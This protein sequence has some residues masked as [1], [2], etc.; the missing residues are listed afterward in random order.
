[1][2]RACPRYQKGYAAAISSYVS[3]CLL[4]NKEPWPVSTTILEEWAVTRIYGTTLS[5]QGQIKSDTVLS[6]LSALKS[7]HIDM[8]LSLKNF[9]DTRM[10]LIIKSGRRLFP[11]KKWNRLPI[12]NIIFEK[13]TEDKPLSVTD[14][15]VNTAFKVAWAGL[16]RMEEFTYKAAEAKK[17]TFAE[18]GLTR[19]DI[20]FAEGDQYAILRLK[21]SKTDTEHTGVQIILAAIVERTCPVAALR[22]LFIQ[23][24][25]QANTPLFRLQSEAFSLQGVVNILKQRIAAEGLS[26]SNFSGHNFRKEAAQHAADHGILDES[27]Q[28]LGRWTS[29]AFKLYFTTTPETLFN[30]NL[31][32]QKG[33][34]LAVPRATMQGPIVTML[35]GPIPQQKVSL[36]L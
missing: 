27:I 33:I 31:S 15:N 18:T 29:N 19:S 24:A 7:Y 13:I 26:E 25:R 4:H 20:S 9:Y 2:V 11:S 16:M 8:R 14:L 34:P 5:K 32:F 35:R 6:Y 17:A 23:D 21:R 3:F 12:T 1:M 36:K 30:L 28:K 10:A 22:R